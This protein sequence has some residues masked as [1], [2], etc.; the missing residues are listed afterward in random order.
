M[1]IVYIDID[2]MR[3]D[4]FGC[5][6]YHRDTTPNLD[7]IAREGTRFDRAYCNTSPCV[8]A[9]ASLMSGRFGVH[10]GAMTHWGPGST[11]RFPG[12]GHDY[13]ADMPLFT[14]HLRQHGYRTVSFS[15]F[16]D[17]HQA[18]WFS[19]GWSEL[20]VPTLKGGSESADEINAEVLPWLE[21][22]GARDD[23]FLHLQYWDPHRDY[24]IDQRWIDLFADDP[25]PDW[26]DAAAIE[27][28]QANYGP[29]TASELFTNPQARSPLPTMPDRIADVRDWKWYVDGYDASIRYMDDRVGQVLD[30]LD[31]LGV[32]DETAVVVSSDHGEA[33]GEQGV[34][35][36]HVCA[37][38]SVHHIPMIV[39]WPGT[40][41][42]GRSYDGFCYNVDLQPTLCDLLGIPTPVGWDGTS[43]ADAV[44]GG[45]W[46]GRPHLVWDHALYTCQRAVRDRDWLYI[47]TYHPGLYPFD[48]EMLFDMRADP[49]QTRNVAGEHTDVVARLDHVMSDWLHEALDTQG[50]EQDP[51]REV[52]RGGGPFRYVS[53]DGW[54]TRLRARGREDDAARIV[55]RLGL[56]GD[57]RGRG[58]TTRHGGAE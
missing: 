14:R 34:Y 53:L 8:P 12:V 23:Y 49:H 6:G 45:T 29:F 3:P 44:R 33:M 25:P 17:R 36:D 37:G 7:R 46:S 51:M 2:T 35:G 20:H 43:F 38:E 55:A 39:R 40:G 26:P 19:A 42:A 28:H 1:R 9:R 58:V 41:G 48:D 24:T 5:Y 50:L 22:N 47:R 15:S 32:L 16:A 11:F 18:G 30:A 52:I 21:R 27:E 31:R 54:L 10:H 4:H 56:A 57:G 13:W